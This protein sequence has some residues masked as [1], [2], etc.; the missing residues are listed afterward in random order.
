MSIRFN[1]MWIILYWIY[2]FYAKRKN[3]LDYK[4]LVSP[5]EYEK[6][7]RVILKYFQ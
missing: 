3:L 6:N 5:N 2:S 4:N 1:N 7:D